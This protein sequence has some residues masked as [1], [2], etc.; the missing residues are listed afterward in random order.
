MSNDPLDFRFPIEPKK[1]FIQTA[2]G[3]YSP[4]EGAVSIELTPTLKLKNC[5]YVPSLSQKLLSVSHVTKELNCTL[6]MHPHFCLL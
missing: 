4:V 5:L 6:L 3:G 2:N 1:Y